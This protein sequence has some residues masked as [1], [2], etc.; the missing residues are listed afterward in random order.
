MQ[1]NQIFKETTPK[2]MFRISCNFVTLNMKYEL[3]N[4]IQG[5]GGDSKTNFIQ[6]ITGFL[7]AGKKTSTANEGKEYTKQEEEE[8]LIDYIE[9]HNLWYSS[10][11]SDYNKIGEGAEQK[12]Y[13]FPDNGTVIK[14]N[15]AIFFAYWEDYL[16]NLIIHNY[17]FPD[18]AYTLIGFKRIGTTLYAVVNQPHIVKTEDIDLNNVKEFLKQNGFQNTKRNDYYN[19]V[20]GI[21]LED[22]HDEN[23]ISANQIP[24]FVDTVF[25]L[26]PKFFEP[27]Y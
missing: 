2:K 17:F 22:L 11:F 20:L 19:K 13:Y 5:K 15:D 18:T 6:Q 1:S 9:K 27:D 7:R 3:Q 10:V 21:I 25:Y 12:V 16:N 26:T 24:F 4:L 14:I 23:V 8:R